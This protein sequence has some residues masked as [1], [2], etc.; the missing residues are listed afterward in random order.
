M[1]IAV[2]EIAQETD[3]FSPLTAELK[4]FK[5]YGLYF[6]PEILQ[7]MPGVG[8][9]GGF[10]EIAARQAVPITILPIVRAFGSAGGTIILGQ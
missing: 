8:P 5:S 2:A 3:S 1:R 9:I 4:D 6:G 10:L 7:R